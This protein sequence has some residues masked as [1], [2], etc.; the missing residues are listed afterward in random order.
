MIHH[1]CFGR[2]M[3]YCCS[4]RRK[5]ITWA[6]ALGSGGVTWAAAPNAQLA[7]LRLNL[8]LVSDG[9]VPP[10]Q[11]HREWSTK[12]T[13]TETETKTELETETEFQSSDP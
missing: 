3:L 4:I 13:E 2:R 7:S 11:P 9:E 8:K 1:Y 10:P 5:S 6:A 12:E